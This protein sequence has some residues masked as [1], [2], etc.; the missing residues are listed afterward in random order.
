M[1]DLILDNLCWMQP[2]ANGNALATWAGDNTFLGW[3]STAAYL[4]T[5]ILCIRAARRRSSQ[6]QGQLRRFWIG[7]ALLLLVL[8]LNKQLDVQ[9]MLTD[10]ARSA[11]RHQGWYENRSV[12]QII[13]VAALAMAAAACLGWFVW[14][15]RSAWRG[16]ALALFGVGLLI[17]F[18]ILR[19]A[20][21][22]RMGDLLGVP[23]TASRAKWVLEL[24]GIFCIAL[25]AVRRDRRP[26]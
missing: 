8:G 6:D 16:H 1:P 17:G 10:A 12:V 15:T 24:G 4:V 19:T 5:S 11:A 18:V 20:Y 7:L 22:E 3:L 26:T 14:L 13:F 21:F 9:T 25:S 23:L 2:I